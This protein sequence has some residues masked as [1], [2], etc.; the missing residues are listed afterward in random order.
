MATLPNR[1]TTKQAISV[2]QRSASG[3][4]RPHLC[5]REE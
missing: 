5:P 1:T 3:P 4:G 2:P